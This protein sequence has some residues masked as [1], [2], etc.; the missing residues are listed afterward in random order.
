MKIVDL[1]P[2]SCETSLAGVIQFARPT[3]FVSRFGVKKFAI[4]EY[5]SHI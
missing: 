3:L 2:K 1:A 4:F 5:N